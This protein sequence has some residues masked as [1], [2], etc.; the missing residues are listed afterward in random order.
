MLLCEWHAGNDESLW[1]FSSEAVLCGFSFLSHGAIPRLRCLYRVGGCFSRW[2]FGKRPLKKVS[3]NSPLC[4]LYCIRSYR[5][6]TACDATYFSLQK[7]CSLTLQLQ[8]PVLQVSLAATASWRTNV[9][10]LPRSLSSKLFYILNTH[11]CRW[12][13]GW[14][15]PPLINYSNLILKLWKALARKVP[16]SDKDTIYIYM[17]LVPKNDMHDHCQESQAQ[18]SNLGPQH[19]Q[20]SFLFA[21]WGQHLLCQF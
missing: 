18:I 17:L 8:G 16:T 15:L 6:S 3:L 19:V 9:L 20:W 5:S 1:D 14:R 11:S 21:N 12:N 10:A 2:F 13:L 4:H 7:G